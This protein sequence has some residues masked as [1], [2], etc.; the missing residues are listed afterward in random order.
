[1]YCKLLKMVLK[2]A[3]RYDIVNRRRTDKAMAKL[4][5]TK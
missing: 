3:C 2:K 4:K 1:M 5:R